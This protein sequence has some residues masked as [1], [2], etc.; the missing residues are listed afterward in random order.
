MD[1]REPPKSQRILLVAN[2]ACSTPALCT[3]IREHAERAAE[4]L[5]VAPVVGSAPHRWMSDDREDR[6]L[7]KERLDA[8]VACLRKH[9]L[10]AH[11]TLGD[12]DPVQGIDD[13]LFGFPADEIVI[14]LEEPEK[15][16]WRHKSIVERARERF[17]IPVIELDVGARQPTPL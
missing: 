2:E 16:Q 7:A 11:G 14:C 9:G 12:A 8:S 4:I 15:R 6:A 5:V 13:A 3:E 10:D 1:R 17:G